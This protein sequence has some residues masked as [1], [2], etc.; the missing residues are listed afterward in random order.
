MGGLLGVR[1]A[2]QEMNVVALKTQQLDFV[3]R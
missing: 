1:W 3:L 2:G